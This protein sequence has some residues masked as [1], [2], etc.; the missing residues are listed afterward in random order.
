MAQ[1]VGEIGE[2]RF[3]KREPAEIPSISIADDILVVSSRTPL[4]RSRQDD[5]EELG[6]AGPYGNHRRRARFLLGRTMITAGSRRELTDVDV[7]TALG[8]HV[9]GDW[10]D[11]IIRAQ[12]LP[13]HI[14][15]ST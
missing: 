8:R 12:M 10:G 6:M 2:L 9:R 14:Q 5:L 13:N 3:Q 15:S 7:L 1:V 11:V 4:D